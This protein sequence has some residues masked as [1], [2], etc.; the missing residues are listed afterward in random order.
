MAIDCSGWLRRG[1]TAKDLILA[2]I[3]RIGVSGGTGHVIEYRGEAIRALSMEGR[4]TV[5]NMSIEAGARAGMIA[6]DETTYAY[7][8]DRPHAPKGNAWDQSL[9]RWR[10]L[11]SDGG[12]TFDQRVEVDAGALSPMITW[13]TNPSMSVP[14]DGEIPS[15]AE[16]S[17]K[18]ALSYMKLDPGRAVRGLPIDVVFI[19]SCTNGRIEDL[20]Q[21]ANVLRGKHVASN[22]RLFVVPGSQTVKREAESRGLAQVFVDAGGEWRESGCSMCVAMNG[23]RVGEGQ[24]AVSTTNRN[25]EGR[26]GTGARTFLASPLTA[27]A[28]AVAGRIIDPREML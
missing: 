6:P 27:A 14:V 11:P 2:I 17:A 16:P 9:E 1:V 26:Q 19:G 24:Y 21:A 12:A 8:R 5:C 20:Q 23:D 7:L 18:R 22:V 10:A 28:A 15:S 3:G 25:F 13:G 4:M